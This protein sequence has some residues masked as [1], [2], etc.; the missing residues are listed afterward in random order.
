MRAVLL[1]P[2]KLRKQPADS[3]RPGEPGPLARTFPKQAQ[4]EAVQRSLGP[5]QQAPAEGEKPQEQV[6]EINDNEPL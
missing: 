5:L 2:G 6:F 1:N 3:A 4:A